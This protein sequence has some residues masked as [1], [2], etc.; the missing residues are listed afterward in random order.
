MK[1]FITILF[2]IS[3]SLKGFSVVYYVSNAGNNSNNGTSTGTAWQTLSKIGT[4]TFNAGDVISIQRGSTFL[5]TLPVPSAG[6]TYTAYGSGADPIITAL[7]SLTTWTNLGS[8]IWEAN[9]NSGSSLT[10]VTIANIPV[11]MGRYPNYNSTDGGFLTINSHTFTN[12]GNNTSSGSVTTS[13]MAGSWV[14]A[15]I[16]MRSVEWVLDRNTVASQSAQTINYTNPHDSHE[17][18]NGHGFFI[19]NHVN[20]LDAQNEWYYNSGTSKLRMYSTVNPSGLNVKASVIERLVDFQYGNN[21]TISN[22]TFTGADE[23]AIRAFFVTGMT[24]QNCRIENIGVDGIRADGWT[25]SIITNCNIYR[26]NNCGI[27]AS[28]S[29]SITISFNT[30]IRCGLLPGM[31][32][33]NNQQMDGIKYENASGSSIINNNRVDSVGYCGIKFNGH[34][35]IVRNNYVSNFCLTIA[36][37][38]GIYSNGDNPP[39]GTYRIVEDNTVLYGYGQPFG[40][41]HSSPSGAIGIYFDDRSY[42]SYIRR[43]TIGYCSRDAI[44][45]H[46]SQD[47]I[48]TDNLMYNNEIGV[49]FGHDKIAPEVPTRNIV[50]KRNTIVAQLGK[51]L[52]ENGTIENDFNLQFSSLDS[53]YYARPGTGNIFT[54]NWGDWPS[55]PTTYNDYTLPGWK[56]AYP[57]Y[58]LNSTFTSVPSDPSQ[59]RVEYNTTSSPVTRLLPGVYRDLRNNQYNGTITIPAYSS[60]YLVYSSALQAG[61]QSNAIPIRGKIVIVGP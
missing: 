43:N 25:S 3:I 21:V 39:A 23:Y 9:V 44:L 27:D 46:N 51:W 36:D 42:R 14:G 54:T 32:L 61:G 34:N 58:D 48:V 2:L 49:L 47:M 12:N 30:V 5:E 20:T 40:A 18:N 17:P 8:N 29:T 7:Q 35:T 4:L 41:G 38:G 55:V 15:E 56:A 11:A 19:Q 59:T 26:I 1:K 16:V 28:Y 57:A 31:G 50:F 60:S 52:I 24:V 53:N 37:G 10:M 6:V 45:L 13:G 22:I 33:S